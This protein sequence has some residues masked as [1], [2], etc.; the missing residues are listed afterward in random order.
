MK[1]RK[2][3]FWIHQSSARKTDKKEEIHLLSFYTKKFIITLVFIRIFEK[4]PPFVHSPKM[5]GCL[6]NK[7]KIKNSKVDL[8]SIENQA[9]DT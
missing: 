3:I 1:E 5:H 8:L 9:F 4:F 6:I 7:R 2:I